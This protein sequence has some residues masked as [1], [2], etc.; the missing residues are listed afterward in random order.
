MCLEH[1]LENANVIS[2]REQ[3]FGDQLLGTS[4]C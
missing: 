2:F 3:I 1:N 4:V